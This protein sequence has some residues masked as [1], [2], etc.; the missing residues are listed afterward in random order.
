MHDIHYGSASSLPDRSRR[1]HPD[2]FSRQVRK[3]I[4]DTRRIAV[5]GTSALKNEKQLSLF[6]H[7]WVSVDVIGPITGNLKRILSARPRHYA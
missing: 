4:M 3:T 5:E 1:S 2:F 7:R 6:L